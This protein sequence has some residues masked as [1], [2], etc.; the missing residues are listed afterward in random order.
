MEEIAEGLRKKELALEKLDSNRKKKL[1]KM[2]MTG[3]KRK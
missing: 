3:S 1:L 2:A